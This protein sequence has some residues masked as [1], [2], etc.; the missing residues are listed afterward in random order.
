MKQV[1]WFDRKFYFK[2]TQNVFP[3]LIERLRGTPIR[4]EEKVKNTPKEELTK[5]IDQSWS[6][7]ENIGHLIEVEPLWQER[8]QDIMNG[9]KE[10]RQADLTNRR[11]YEGN[12]NRIPVNDILINF[13]V[14][15]KKT[16]SLLESLSE[17][18]IFK[19]S[20]HPRLKEP[21][22]VFDL[23]YFVAEHDDHHLARIQELKM[24]FHN[25]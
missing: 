18:D 3:G 23:F 19:T 8:L 22:S 21:M 12:Y 25:M 7:Q 1:A 2:E 9:E 6:F 11:T 14:L 10:L 24:I 4:L 17:E 5:Q 13:R 16:V 15:R 20:L